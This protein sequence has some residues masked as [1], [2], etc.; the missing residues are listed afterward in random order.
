MQSSIGFRAGRPAQRFM[1]LLFAWLGSI[2]VHSTAVAGDVALAQALLG[3]ARELN[4]LGLYA[5]AELGAAFAKVGDV[6]ASKE[7]FAHAWTTA[8]KIEDGVERRIVLY[9][10]ATL[11]AEA[12]QVEEAIVAAKR[13]PSRY[14]RAM[15]FGQIAIAQAETGDIDCELPQHW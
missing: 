13:L 7:S 4:G 8:A 11:Q 10:I 1:F 6:E 14:E 3:E 9:G 15:C 2:N 12:G 5:S